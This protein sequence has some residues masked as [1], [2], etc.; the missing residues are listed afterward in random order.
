MSLC[1][2][3]CVI[4]FFS[5]STVSLIKFGVPVSEKTFLNPMNLKEYC[6]NPDVGLVSEG[7]SS[8]KGKT[9][10]INREWTRFPTST[11][12]WISWINC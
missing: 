10:M 4:M 8:S 1:T 5:L 6:K 9:G 11:S 3:C 2:H 12:V 7:M